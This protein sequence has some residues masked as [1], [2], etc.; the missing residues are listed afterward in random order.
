[1]VPFLHHKRLSVLSNA[2]SALLRVRVPTEGMEIFDGN[3]DR[4]NSHFFFSKLVLIGACR[5]PSATGFLK[6]C[7]ADHF[8]Q[9]TEYRLGVFFVKVRGRGVGGMK[10]AGLP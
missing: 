10:T 8:R 5:I 3:Q 6:V 7:E 1:M 9:G 4:K 2:K